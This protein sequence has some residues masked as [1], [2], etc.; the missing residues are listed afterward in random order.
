M[1]IQAPATVGIVQGQ[2]RT[3]AGMPIKAQSPNVVQ[4][5]ARCQTQRFSVGDLVHI[6]SN[7]KN[8]W[9]KNGEVIDVLQVPRVSE[10]PSPPAGV[11]MPVGAVRVSS[12]AGTKWIMPDAIGSQIRKVETG[13]YSAGEHVHIWSNS[14]NAW[15][16]DGEVL[17]VLSAPRISE[18]G[19]I[20][21]GQLLPAGCVK[22]ASTAGT[23]W[24]L[25]DLV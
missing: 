7:S 25:P 10:G 6:W 14:M 23:K 11:M 21:A 20:P 17:E 18:G 4:P 15:M 13:G 24:V 22:V 5:Q 1:Q 8:A 12:V 19:S 16:T 2:A 9:M 3:T